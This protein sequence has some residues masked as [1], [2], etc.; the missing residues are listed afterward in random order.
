MEQVKTLDPSK[1]YYIDE[2]GI[3]HPLYRTHGWSL[4]GEKIFADVPGITT[5]AHQHYLRFAT[6][7]T[8]GSAG[9]SRLLQLAVGQ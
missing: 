5:Q 3:D 7:K 9:F 6:I 1:L 2:S 8:R 4:R